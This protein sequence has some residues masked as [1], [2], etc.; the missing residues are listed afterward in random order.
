M[1]LD[2]SPIFGQHETL[3][4]LLPGEVHAV[5]QDG[6]NWLNEMVRVVT[7]CIVPNLYPRYR[8]YR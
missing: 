8:R 7:V 6:E 3:P 1:Q 5:L 4:M 2:L